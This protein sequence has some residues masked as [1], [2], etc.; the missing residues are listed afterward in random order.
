MLYIRNDDAGRDILVGKNGIK[1]SM[2]RKWNSAVA[3][4][5]QL[6]DVLQNAVKINELKP[7]EGAEGAYILLGYATDEG[8]NDYTAVFV[9][10]EYKN[11]NV[12]MESVDVLYSTNA[13]K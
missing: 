2:Q 10:N 5:S 9:V 12:E 8:G 3:V 6:G 7:R 11:G 1:H 13:K 4:F